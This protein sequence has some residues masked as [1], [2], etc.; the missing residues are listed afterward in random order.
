MKI[1]VI[2]DLAHVAE[3]VRN[4][5]NNLSLKD[6]VYADNS[7]KA[8]ELLQSSHYDMVICEVYLKGLSCLE[9]SHQA[10][11][12]NPDCCV[13][14]MTPLESSDIAEK[15]VKEGA[16]DFLIRPAQIDK[17]DNLIKLYMAV[18]R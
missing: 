14:I 12:K 5:L 7:K 10:R 16:F 8:R 15:A 13:I 3:R 4:S 2:E 11:L 1:L 17:L 18:K 6:A 9:A